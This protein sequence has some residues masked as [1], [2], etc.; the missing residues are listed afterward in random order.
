MPIPRTEAEINEAA[1]A[2]MEGYLHKSGAEW[3]LRLFMGF[4]LLL[5]RRFVQG[6]VEVEH[7]QERVTAIESARESA[8]ANLDRARRHDAA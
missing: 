5:C 6:L 4:A 1:L 7:L 2:I 8:R 3:Y